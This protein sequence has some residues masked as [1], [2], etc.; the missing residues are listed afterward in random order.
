MTAY[1]HP[2]DH[3]ARFRAVRLS[4]RYGLR[5]L[6][7]N[8]TRID[9][10]FLTYADDEAQEAFTILRDEFWSQDWQKEVEDDQG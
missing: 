7:R 4:Q 5:W 2:E 1:E 3:A 8:R 6:E 10:M 9:M